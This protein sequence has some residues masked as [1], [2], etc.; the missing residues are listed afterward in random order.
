MKEGIKYLIPI[1]AAVMVVG[2]GI[3]LY[4]GVIHLNNPSLQEYPVQGVDVSSY[5]GTVDWGVLASQKISFAYIK[6]TE[7]SGMQ[8]EN[9]KSNWKAASKTGLKIGAYHFF[10]F[11][12]SGATQADNYIKTVPRLEGGLP[13]VVDLELYGDFGNKPPAKAVIDSE[14]GAMLAKL[15]A[16]YGK[17]PVIYVTEKCYDLYIRE[18]FSQNPIWIRNVFT[19]PIL[20]DNRKWTFWQYSARHTLRGYAGEERFIDMNAFNG[21]PALFKDLCDPMDR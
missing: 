4:N 12:S 13:P 6:A 18:G 8:D 17:K 2:L 5:Q 7:G 3:L 16:Q 19:K 21:S 15:E 10:S 9:F 11:E 1:L 20:Q 14:L